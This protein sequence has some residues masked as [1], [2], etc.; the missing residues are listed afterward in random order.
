[1][2]ADPTLV[3]VII[4][5]Y[6]HGPYIEQ[7]IL[8][9]LNQTYP[10][11]ELL[12]VDDGS[13]DDSVERIERLQAQHGFDFRVQ[14]NKG[15]THTLNEAIARAKGTLIAPFGSDDIMMPDRI[16]I[17]VQYMADK[18][19]VG[20]CAGNIELIDSQGELFPEARQRREVPFRR[21]DFEDMFLERKPYPPAPT[22]L[23]RREALE[24]V[25]GFDPDIRLEDLLI[26]LKVTHAGYFIDG[27]SVVMA[28]YRKHASNS[29]KNHRFMIDNILRTYAKF[30]DHPAYEQ[31]K[32][33]ALNSMFLKVANRDRKLARELLAQI[34]LRAYTRKTW[35]GLGRL[36]FSPLEKG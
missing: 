26:E 14:R 18:P 3:T 13:T 35:R 20:I 19:E 30:K 33:K 11:I 28:R 16:A 17:Q 6:N 34:P 22:L 12:V 8:S 7:S 2:S 10:H 9:V 32:F 25:G 24:K 5:S 27:L 29:Y 36:F 23:I 15:L 4:A 1:M 21:L 31:V